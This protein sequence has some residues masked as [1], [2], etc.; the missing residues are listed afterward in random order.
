MVKNL[1]ANAGDC[2]RRE[3]DPWVREIS[4][5]R[6]WQ[7]TPVFL[8]G[9]ISWTEEPGRLWGCDLVT[10]HEDTALAVNLSYS[11]NGPY[12]NFSCV[13]ICMSASL[14]QTQGTCCLGSLCVLRLS[15]CDGTLFRD[16][17]GGPVV[18]NLPCK[19]GDRSSI[20]GRG[21]RIPRG[22]GGSTKPMHKHR[23]QQHH[24]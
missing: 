21:A 1:L 7:P 4:W 15:D 23:G 20:P 13:F 8:P 19:A 18:K 22:S 12:S 11:H 14:F 2:R 10:E 3:F 16:F 5:R 6:K 9:K 17:P 24:S